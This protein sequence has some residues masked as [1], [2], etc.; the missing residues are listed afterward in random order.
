MF[1]LLV[2]FLQVAAQRQIIG[3]LELKFLDMSVLFKSQSERKRL[4][5][6]LGAGWRVPLSTI[7]EVRLGLGII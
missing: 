3:D 4:S 2:V 7:Y 6:V 1:H 5:C